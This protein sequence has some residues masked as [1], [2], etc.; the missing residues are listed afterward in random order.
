MKNNHTQLRRLAA[1][2]FVL[3]LCLSALPMLAPSASAADGSLVPIDN[4]QIADRVLL[5]M[6][7]DDYRQGDLL[8]LTDGWRLTKTGDSPIIDAREYEGSMASRFYKAA[9]DS[10]DAF[11]ALP[12]VARYNISWDMAIE[13][14]TGVQDFYFSF[15]SGSQ[16]NTPTSE[17]ALLKLFRSAWPA[18]VPDRAGLLLPGMGAVTPGAQTIR[19]NETY[20]YEISIDNVAH[21]IAS[22]VSNATYSYS[23]T[24]TF[25]S[26][27]LSPVPELSHVLL[28]TYG[29]NGDLEIYIDNLRITT[30]ANLID[31][32]P[33]VD[34]SGKMMIMTFDDNSRSTV[35]RGL[36]IFEARGM[37]GDVAIIVNSIVDGTGVGD[38]GNYGWDDLRLLVSHGWGVASHSLSHRDL[39]AIPLEQAQYEILQSKL[40]IEQNLTG[41]TVKRICAPF[42]AWNTTLE[43]YARSVGY[44][45]TPYTMVRHNVYISMSETSLENRLRFQH[46]SLGSVSHPLTH[47]IVAN[48]TNQFRITPEMLEWYLDLGVP[49]VSSDRYLQY[50]ADVLAFAPTNIVR[51]ATTLEFHNNRDGVVVAV[52][53]ATLNMTR[54]V[55]VSNSNIVDS[56]IVDGALVFEA[57]V[58]SYAIMSMSAYYSDRIDDAMSPL[59]AIIP[60]VIAL[61]VLG[62]IL[63]M[64]GRVRF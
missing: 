58:G 48:T 5:D 7:F 8:T 56:I 27:Y 11:L 14:W 13:D 17:H 1:I 51:S 18:D 10:Y 44:V 47:A 62:S 64:V 15:R 4:H 39:T 30:P 33:G 12:S 35:V 46:Y 61:A 43:N 2:S 42:D 55:V 38:V 29:G 20:H 31:A 16:Y 25:K 21:T 49:S 41:Y 63:A 37:T 6:N 59:Y 32:W 34:A 22:T 52:D 53:T 3:M 60:V 24:T 26:P 50:R 54:P 28:H 45:I 36:P 23:W 40:R 19:L 57:D 9:G